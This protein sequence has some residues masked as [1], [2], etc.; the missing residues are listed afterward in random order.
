MSALSETLVRVFAGRRCSV[1][2]PF[3]AL[4]VVMHVCNVMAN[5]RRK[6]RA[7]FP[8][9]RCSA[10]PRDVEVLYLQLTTFV[11]LSVDSIFCSS[12]F[13]VN[14]FDLDF[15][16]LEKREPRRPGLKGSVGWCRCHVFFVDF[17]KGRM[18]FGV[19][20]PLTVFRSLPCSS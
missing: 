3:A 18:L 12:R 13:G 8:L 20:P 9:R 10:L 7:G 6:A 17:A 14:V 1:M 16:Q 19:L 2:K 15:P 11:R 5:D 4:Q